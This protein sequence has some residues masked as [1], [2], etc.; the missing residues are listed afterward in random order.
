MKRIMIAGLAVFLLGSLTIN[1][2]GYLP[3]C[4][5]WHGRAEAKAIGIDT[6]PLPSCS[7]VWRTLT[8]QVTGGTPVPPVVMFP[9]CLG[10]DF[11][12]GIQKAWGAE[13]LV[14]PPFDAAKRYAMASLPD[15]DGDYVRQ[16]EID[17]NG[18]QSRI[19][20]AYIVKDRRIVIFKDF[21][22]YVCSEDDG[23][24]E[25]GLLTPYGLMGVDVPS[26]KIIEECFKIFRE[27]VTR[28]LLG[29]RI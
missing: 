15:E 13:T 2:H 3:V 25:A 12:Y 10:K 9:G 23:S 28:N 26:E 18:E 29:V 20:L 8:S 11:H 5:A 16:F 21:A 27:L 19:A 6:S 1:M 17:E 4:S 7:D 14:P 22:G 24:L